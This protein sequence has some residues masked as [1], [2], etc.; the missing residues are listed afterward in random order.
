MLLP[1]L[2]IKE[3]RVRY[4]EDRFF[5]LYNKKVSP[6]ANDGEEELFWGDV[7]N[8]LA[9]HYS[10]DGRIRIL[11][12]GSEFLESASE[13]TPISKLWA[14]FREAEAF[15]QYPVVAVER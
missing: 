4:T 10:F 12:Q 15:N 13:K 14:E 7:L 11:E 9:Q 6:Y 1:L 3:L 8:P 5:E 2:Q